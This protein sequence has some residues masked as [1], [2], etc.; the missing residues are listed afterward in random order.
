MFVIN[1]AILDIPVLDLKSLGALLPRD[2]LRL[3]SAQEPAHSAQYQRVSSHLGQLHHDCKMP[4]SPP[5]STL[6]T[7]VLPGGSLVTLRGL[8][9][10]VRSS[11]LTLPIFNSISWCCAART[12]FVLFLRVCACVPPAALPFLL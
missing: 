2:R 3:R 12:S 8:L 1:G 7:T 5:L 9:P 6:A 4:L 10:F 11:E